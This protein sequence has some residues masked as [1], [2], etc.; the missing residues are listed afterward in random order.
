MNIDK[1]ALEQIRGRRKQMT[2]DFDPFKTKGYEIQ[3]NVCPWRGRF[4]G[5]IS[6]SEDRGDAYDDSQ[7]QNTFPIRASQTAA[8]GIKSGISPSSRPWF[9]VEAEDKRVAEF[10]GPSAYL[11]A[12]ERTLYAIFQRA[13]VYD[14]LQHAYQEIVDFGT[15]AAMVVPD[16][17]TIIR[18]RP[19]TYGEYQLANDHKGNPNTFARSFYKSVS[20]LVG[21]FGEANVS[22]R[23]KDAHKNG[24]MEQRILCQCLIEPNDDRYAVK[25]ALGRDFR[26]IY[27]EDGQPDEKI[28]SVRGF[29]NYPVLTGAW[30]AVGNQV[31]GYG[32]GHFNLRNCKRLQAMESD[33][34]QQLALSIKPPLLANVSNKD[35]VVNTSPWGITH[36]L[37]GMSGTRP[38][39]GPLYQVNPNTQAIEQ[40]IQNTEKAI[41]DGFYNN[42]FMMIANSAED[43]KTAYQ[44]ARMMEEKYSVLGPVIER[45]QHMLGQ[46]IKLT[47]AEALDRGLF[48]DPPPE[49]EG[50]E[51]KIEY[52]SILAQAQKISGLQSIEQTIGFVGQAVDIWPE[53]RHKVDI[54]QA[55]DEIA[56]VNG[57][58]ASVVR[59]DDEVDEMM[60]ADAAAAQQAK[61]AEQMQ[62]GAGMAKDLAGVNIQ[63]N[64]ALDVLAGAGA[65][66]Q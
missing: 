15:G 32:L 8:A 11:S 56:Q 9:R 50:Q 41:Y 20:Q 16:V 7:I 61:Q 39:V 22:S 30:E 35:T 27:W 10:A 43:I 62:Q 12:V 34:L 6:E 23:T 65:S 21:E 37:S 60:A 52:I 64:S 54:L 4:L 42:I 25:D 66:G 36:D 18:L 49:L 38:G 29:D 13:N 17:D 63:G 58:P 33:K 45:L 57:T 5:G 53:A 19:F 28:L 3:Q 1:K 31:Y 59:P 44:T 55:I 14:S 48:P 46:L 2:D 47:F 40:S 51:L 24:K 26:A